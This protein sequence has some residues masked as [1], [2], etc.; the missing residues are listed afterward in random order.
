M[1]KTALALAIEA[2]LPEQLGAGLEA[3]E[4][5]RAAI[6]AELNRLIGLVDSGRLAS[7]IASVR[8][9]PGSQNISVTRHGDKS[10]SLQSAIYLL[11]SETGMPAP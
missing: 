10:I 1:K 7:I 5:A 11:Q 9:L 8:D 6:K 4:I 2:A 3:L